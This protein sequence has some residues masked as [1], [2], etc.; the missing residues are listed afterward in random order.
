MCRQCDEVGGEM[1]DYIVITTRAFI[2]KLAAWTWVGA[3]AGV[4]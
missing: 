1:G 4:Q 3:P 2:L